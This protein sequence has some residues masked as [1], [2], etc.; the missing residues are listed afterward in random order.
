MHTRGVVIIVAALGITFGSVVAV[1]SSAQPGPGTRYLALGDSLA[2]SYQ[3]TG[4]LRSGYAEQV[5]QLE[6]ASR[7]DLRLDKLGCPGERTSTMDKPKPRCPYAEG[8][9]L[10]Q[11]VAVLEQGNVSF[12]T[13]QIGSNDLFVKCFRLHRNAYDQACVAET[14]PKISARLTSI[15]E[16]LQAADPNVPIVGGTYYDRLIF[17]WTIPGIDR[18]VVMANTD[19]SV[20]LN[21]MLEQ[22]YEALGVPVA[23]IQSAFS[24]TDFDTVVHARGI[25]DVPLNV[26]RACEWTSMCSEEFGYD[27]HPNDIGY[28][29][30]TRAWEGALASALA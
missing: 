13:L 5:L 19:V 4:D 24:M 14:L 22:T 9:Q 1:T 30:L 6:Q 29:Q 23:D 12:V 25:G 15:V 10:A 8:T 18:D 26:A 20:A 11:A 7:N 21:H 28:A 27:P 3:P 17:L 2:A 16:T